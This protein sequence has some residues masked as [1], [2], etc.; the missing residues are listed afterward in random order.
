VALMETAQGRSGMVAYSNLIAGGPLRTWRILGDSNVDWDQGWRTLKRWKQTTLPV[1]DGLIIVEGG[2]TIF[3]ASGL[4]VQQHRTPKQ[5]ATDDLIVGPVRTWQRL[6]RHDGAR[7]GK[8]GVAVVQPIQVIE[9]CLL[10]FHAEPM[11]RYL[12]ESQTV[13]WIDFSEK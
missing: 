6:T 4:H 12:H 13:S 8:G 1:T 10:V 3:E 5:F 7:L 11:K 2:Y 9:G